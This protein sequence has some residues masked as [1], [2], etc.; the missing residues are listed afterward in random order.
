MLEEPAQITDYWKDWQ[1]SIMK[2]ENSCSVFFT[3]E[4][5]TDR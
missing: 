2:G 5:N 3:F 4:R 1:A